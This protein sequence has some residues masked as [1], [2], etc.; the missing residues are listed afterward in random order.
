MKAH[1]THLFATSLD[2]VC[3]GARRHFDNMGKDS[4]WVGENVVKAAAHFLSRTF[5]VY[6]AVENSSPLM[7]EPDSIA[8]RTSQ[9][10]LQLAYYEFGHY[11]AVKCSASAS[12]VTEDPN[13]ATKGHLN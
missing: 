7:Y 12:R 1:C 10:P 4:V 2:V 6:A 8:S 13:E 3:E 5:H 9:Q 11:R